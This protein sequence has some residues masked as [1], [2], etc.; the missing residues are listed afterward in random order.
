LSISELDLSDVPFVDNHAHALTREQPATPAQL[1]RHFSEAHS[2]LLSDEHVGSA[3][4]FRWALRQLGALLGIEPTEEAILARREELGLPAYARRLAIAS[5]ASHLLLDEGYPPPD[6]GFSSDEMED[7]LGVHIGRMLRIETL[8]QDLILRH[9]EWPELPAA[10]DAALHEARGY[11]ALKSIAAY[12][13][14]LAVER[15]SEAEAARAFEPVRGEAAATGS[16][17]LSSKPLID[18]FIWRA[19]HFAA[20][21][22]IPFQFHTGFGDPDLDLRLAN[23]LHLRPLFEDR[24]LATVPIVLLHSSFPYTAEAA[25]LCAAYPNA[26]LDLAFSLPPLDRF[27]LIRILHIAL[28]V[29]P[30][31]KLMC[32]SDGTGIPEHYYLGAARARGCLAEA[33]T[34]LIIAGEIDHVEAEATGRML[35][36]GNAERVYNL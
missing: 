25:Y 29:A 9:S 5:G 10:F 28:G 23:P 8:V 21:R 15:V 33:L 7:M 4:N 35:L 31:S 34:S 26:Y 2:P 36:H 20:G 1:R 11:V 32:S 24:A 14:G 27:E 13:S 6:L 18:F 3:V 30:A 22:E 16:V 12:R 19:A 17:R